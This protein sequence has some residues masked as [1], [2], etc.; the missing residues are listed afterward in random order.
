MMT[1]D[2]SALAAEIDDL[3]DRFPKLKDDE[4]FIV[5]FV[6]ALLV[7]DADRAADTLVGGSKDKSVD[8]VCIDHDADRVAIV[9]GKY[10]TVGH[11][12]EKRPEVL[13]FADLAA[14]LLDDSKFST[15]LQDSAPAVREKMKLA[16]A[17]VVKK[18]YVLN[19][20]YVTTR[21]VSPA[22]RSEAEKTAKSA[23][24]RLIVLHR[25]DV[26]SL[27]RDYL[28]GVAPPVPTVELSIETSP[29]SG[30][31]KRYDSQT[32]I[33]SWIFSARAADVAEL[34][35][36]HGTKIFARNIRGYLGHGD[37]NSVNA[38]I[39]QTLQKD[40]SHFWY[41]NNGVTI[42]CDGAQQVDTG[43]KLV[44]Q[45][46]N[47]QIVNGQQTTV[48]LA[49][50]KTPPQASVLVRVV[51]LPKNQLD[52]V[53]DIVKATNRQNPIRPSDLMAN[54]RTQVFLQRKLRL[55]SY[56]YLRKR[57]GRK[58]EAM[59]VGG[60]KADFVVTKEELA[61]AV[62]AC[63]LDP[64]VVRSAREALFDELTYPQVF[65]KRSVDYYLTR[66]WLVKFMSRYAWGKGADRQY[67]K[68][69]VAH[70]VWDRVGKSIFAS[71]PAFIHACEQWHQDESPLRELSRVTEFTFKSVERFFSRTRKEEGRVLEVYAFFKRRGKYDEFIRFMTEPEQAKLYDQL[72]KSE[73]EF[74]GVLKVQ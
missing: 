17:A 20:Y 46:D 72:I 26:L 11:T 36:K 25:A 57:S 31:I 39:R 71:S 6:N 2:M 19:L 4:L 18:G 62:A 73:V 59:A 37:E 24:S 9:Q 43:G 16:R 40:P 1:S 8:A 47:P 38:A 74:V 60:G 58:S 49:D 68:F 64:Q 41:F 27:L 50:T 12:T 54:D 7:D 65:P 34:Y 48:T 23:Q 21:S 69:F 51:A 52:L 28:D 55:R 5:W 14:V 3:R 30:V 13:A 22:L 67:M 42:A 10:S 29:A 66:W 63:D 45:M 53:D 15:W 70:A 32:Q 44:L 35:T 33:T 61:Q 56:N